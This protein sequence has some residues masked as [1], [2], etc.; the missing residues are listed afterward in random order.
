MTFESL[1]SSYLNKMKKWEVINIIAATG[2]ERC[3]LNNH[4]FCPP[5]HVTAAIERDAE[6]LRDP[7]YF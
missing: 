3:L 1:F 4:L 7:T 2:N 5:D 6:I